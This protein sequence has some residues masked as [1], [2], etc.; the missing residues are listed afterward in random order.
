MV[1]IIPPV[2]LKTCCIAEMKGN[3][4]GFETYVFT[5]ILPSKKYVLTHRIK[6]QHRTSY[7]FQDKTTGLE[8]TVECIFRTGIIANS[9]QTAPKSKNRK[10]SHFLILGLGGTA[11]KPD[12]VFL[13]NLNDCPYTIL[14]KRHLQHN[15]INA[16]KALTSAQLRRTL[17][18]PDY[19]AKKVA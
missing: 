8:F 9:V 3:E 10:T 4:E 16:A 19:P 7:S 13:V 15:H 6:N 1:T 18:I 14:S 11:D 12:Q 5:T 2:H 17:L